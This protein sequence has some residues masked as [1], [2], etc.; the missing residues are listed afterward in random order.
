MLGYHPDTITL[1]GQQ[2]PALLAGHSAT[3][4][5]DCVAALRAARTVVVDWLHS[6]GFPVRS[7][8]SD[9]LFVRGTDP[10]LLIGV[11]DITELM[12]TKPTRTAMRRDTA[13]RSLD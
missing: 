2:L 11:T 9:S 1:I 4:P 3:A 10:M 13:S 12:W 8:I 6:E 7:V 5:R